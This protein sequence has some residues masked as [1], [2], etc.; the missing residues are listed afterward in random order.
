MNKITQQRN[1]SVEILRIIAMTFVLLTHW[2]WSMLKRGGV[3]FEEQVFIVKYLHCL[4]EAPL[5]ICVNLFIIISGYYGLKLKI[6]NIVNIGI[7]VSSVFFVEYFYFLLNG[8]TGLTIKG[9]IKNLLFISRSDYF[10]VDYILLMFFSPILNSFI[11]N[12]NRKIIFYYSLLAI[13][14]ESY[15]GCVRPNYHF[16][17]KAGYSFIHFVTIYL[18]ARSLNLYKDELFKRSRLF[19]TIIFSCCSLLISFMLYFNVNHTTDY[20]NPLVVLSAVSF[21]MIFAKGDFYNKIINTIAASTFAV[22]IVHR[23]NPI[24]DMMQSCDIWLFENYNYFQYWLLSLSV[25]LAIF[26]GAI[27]FDKIIDLYRRPILK[28]IDKFGI[29]SLG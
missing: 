27:L 8:Q 29:P 24:H 6:R 4:I 11:K 3:N 16:G 23:Y 7:L 14:I 20:C 26:F 28:Y 2:N 13:I 1:S 17:I 5:L 12:H 19:Y 15:F 22:Y 10:V 21:F 9:L 25:L 18:V